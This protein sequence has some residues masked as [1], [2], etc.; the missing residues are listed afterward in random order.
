MHNGKYQAAHTTYQLSFRSCSTRAIQK[1]LTL[2][3]KYLR[4]YW[5]MDH[6]QRN[7]KTERARRLGRKNKRGDRKGESNDSPE[8]PD[9][10][11]TS[12]IPGLPFGSREMYLPI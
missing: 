8:I 2:T 6:E 11:G 10:R 5:R 12:D 9:M 7:Y 4:V 1:S 3:E